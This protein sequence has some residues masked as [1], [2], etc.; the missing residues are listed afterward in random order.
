MKMFQREKL[1]SSSAHPP[2]R[3]ANHPDAI[4]GG[5]VRR[6]QVHFGLYIQ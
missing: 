3:I 5:E 2:S 4:L 1:P 6:G